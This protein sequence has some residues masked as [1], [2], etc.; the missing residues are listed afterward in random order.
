M[1]TLGEVVLLRPIWLIG[2]P[3]ALGI[4]ATLLH[5][6]RALSGWGGVIA[7]EFLRFLES[8]GHVLPPRGQGTPVYLGAVAGLVALA[9]SGPATRDESAPS[10]RNLDVVYLLIDLSDSMTQGGS[11]DD[12]KAAAALILSDAAARPVALALFAGESYLVSPP[13][14]DPGSLETAIAVLSGDT[15]P[16]RG[17]RPDRALADARQVLNDAD[18]RRADLILISDGGGLGPEALHAARVLAAE[19][20]RVSAVF[21][22]PDAPP[23]GM[24]VSNRAAMSQV[25]EAGGGRLA[26]AEDTAAISHILRGSG[27]LTPDTTTAALLL[28]EHGRWFI[29]PALIPALLLFRRRRVA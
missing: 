29:W 2:L 24:P 8:R 5:H 19:G 21:V 14:S 26:D 23:Y 15:L 1:I 6:R 9:L 25:V 3:V 28:R 27:M 20:T 10:F 16:D 12:A 17:S 22:D 11:L 4:V 7:P 13:T 18:A